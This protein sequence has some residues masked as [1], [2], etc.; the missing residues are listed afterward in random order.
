[1]ASRIASASASADAASP[2]LSNDRTAHSGVC[3]TDDGEYASRPGDDDDVARGG[4]VCCATSAIDLK[5]NQIKSVS[6]VATKDRAT[7]VS[8]DDLSRGDTERSRSGVVSHATLRDAAV[9]VRVVAE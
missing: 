2:P 1:M 9:V 4:G 5:S 6:D 3:I 8:R 7:V